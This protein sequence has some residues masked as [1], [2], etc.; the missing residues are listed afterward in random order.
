MKK[1]TFL[2]ILWVAAALM[3][4]AQSP[5]AFKY[6]AVVRNASGDIIANQQ[7]RFKISI[8]QGEAPATAIY[9]EIH[10]LG[11]NAFGLVNLE[12]GTGTAP[13]GNFSTIDWGSAAHHIKLEMDAT[14]GENFVEMGISPLLSVPYALHAKTAENGFSGD[15]N[16]LINQPSL[17]DGQ[18]SSLTGTPFIPVILS[19]LDDVSASAPASGQV[20]KWN[21]ST[22]APSDDLQGGGSGGTYTPGD[23]ISISGSNVISISD[24]GVTSVKLA[25]NAVTTAKVANSAISTEKVADAAITTAKLANTSVTAAKLHQM[26]A[27]SG[28]VLKWNGTTWAPA[29]DLQGSGGSNPTGPAGGDL[30]GTYPNPSIANNAVT[31]AKIAA[32]SITSDKLAA[33]A[34]GSGQLANDAVTSAHIANNAVTSAKIASGAVTATELASNAVTTVKINNAAITSDKLAD[35]AVITA[36][37]ANNAVTIAKLPAGAS[38]TTYLRGD[39]TWATPTSGGGSNWTVSGNNISNSNSGNVGIGTTT[40][41]ALLHTNGMGTGGG[42][43]LFSGEFNAPLQGD[44][45]TSGAGTRIMWYPN[46]AAFRAGQVSGDHWNKDNVGNHSMA[47]GYNVTAFGYYSIAMGSGSIALGPNSLSIGANTNASGQSSVALGT[48]TTASSMYS[49]AMG[50]WTTA[51]GENSTAMGYNTIASGEYATAMGNGAYATGYLSTAMGNATTASRMYSTAMGSWTTASGAISTAMGSSTIAASYN[52]T[53]IGRLNTE[54]TPNS[55]SDWNSADRLFVIGNGTSP[56]NRSNAMTVLKSGNTGLGT[57]TPN[58]LLHTSG[59]GTGEGNVVFEGSFKSSNPG[60][61]PVSGAGTRMMWYPDKAAFRVG[62]VNSTHWDKDSIG[63]FSMALG[64][65]TK[66]QALYSTAMGAYSTASGIVSTAIGAGTT[67]SGEYSTA[68]GWDTKASGPYSTAMGFYT[69]ASANRSMAM[70]G[71]TTASGMASTAMG[72]YSTALGDFSTAMGFYTEASGFISTAIGSSTT[73]KSAYETVIGRY[74]TIYTQ[75]DSLSWN[76]SDRLFVIGNGTSPTNRSNAL[77]MLKNGNTG[78]GIDIPTQKLDI[79]GQV[80]IRGGAPGNGKVLTSDADGVGS[81]QTPSF[82]NWTVS[83]SN[84]Y[85][86]S[87]NVGIG[88]SFPGELLHVRNSSGT[89]RIRIQSTTTSAIDFYNNTAYVAGIGVSVSEGHLFLYNGGNVSVKGGNLGIGN[90]TPGQ[91]LDI[92]AG[93]GRVQ[94]GYNWLTNSD[95]RYKTNVSTLENVLDKIAGINGVRYDLKEDT[96][97]IP[98]HGKHI[99]FIAQELETEFPEFVIT[100]EDGFKSVAYDKVTAVL[101]QAVKEQQK[102]IEEQQRTNEEQKAVLKEQQLLLETLLKRIETLENK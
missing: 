92:T 30:S 20:L 15:Y 86:S 53:V 51:S 95:A 49:T 60:D 33:G 6:Q 23:G 99:G 16:D 85:R 5:Q 57:D 63:H 17:F 35:A 22:W 67:A 31:T 2:I 26:S 65:S 1:L 96:E 102:I 100:G 45:P 12:I 79:D 76:A 38:A 101:L 7:V 69:T 18:Y 32:T 21:G 74:N 10:L 29:E 81:W 25:N 37:I 36:K 64:F 14:G 68:M 93:N 44:P 72:Q 58:A 19:H 27:T 73:A 42:N 62:Y 90:T 75:Q 13:T 87:G 50:S 98:G 9:S 43:V 54:Y 24:A 80:R 84:I 56:T 91:K 11:T 46:K 71:Y 52:E 55:V 83:G 28:Q 94:S 97:I 48:G 78:L 89:A 59:R 61:P 40:P 4:S 70:G 82:S 88:T 41:T 8:L 39:G 3:A 77:T 34:V 66:A 47:L